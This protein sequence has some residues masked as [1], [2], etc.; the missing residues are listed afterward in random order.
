M[1]GVVSVERG[2]GMRIFQNLAFV[3][4]EKKE[5]EEIWKASLTKRS[6]IYLLFNRRIHRRRVRSQDMMTIKERY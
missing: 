2:V 4:G 6:K 3:E 5:E 1:F